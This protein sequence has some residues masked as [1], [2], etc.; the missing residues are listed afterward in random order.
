MTCC[1]RPSIALDG[2]GL[3]AD[4]VVVV[5]FLFEKRSRCS[6][7]GGP[8]LSLGLRAHSEH[9]ETRGPRLFPIR[10]P[11]GRRGK[12]K[13]I[14]LLL[15]V[16]LATSSLRHQQIPQTTSSTHRIERCSALASVRGVRACEAILHAGEIRLGFR[17]VDAHAAAAEAPR[18]G[19]DCGDAGAAGGA[20]PPEGAVGGIGLQ[21]RSGGAAGAP[22][23]GIVG[24]FGLQRRCDGPAGAPWEQGH[25][26]ECCWFER[27]GCRHGLERG[28]PSG[29]PLEFDRV[30]WVPNQGAARHRH[31]HRHSRPAA[32]GCQ[33]EE[34]LQA[35]EFIVSQG[36]LGGLGSAAMVSQDLPPPLLLAI[37]QRRGS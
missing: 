9:T 30:P 3:V 22:P 19:G 27:E 28:D 17:F 36:S 16:A 11:I 5:Y 31:R 10:F 26:L 6:W 24:R 35:M 8:N 33:R 12:R 14:D 15:A 37:Y 25:G 13:P 4:L 23:Q 21:R 18:E 1:C 2:I 20:P 29:E 34:L 32:S 7:A